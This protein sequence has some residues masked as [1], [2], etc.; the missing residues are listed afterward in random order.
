MF[1]GHM[2]G[3]SRKGEPGLGLSRSPA[4][5]HC[6]WNG[7][8]VFST[9]VHSRD[10]TRKVCFNPTHDDITNIEGLHFGQNK[11]V[12]D[13]IKG[14]GKVKVDNINCVTLVYHMRHRFLED[15][16]T[17]ETRPRK[18]RMAASRSFQRFC[19]L[20]I[21]GYNAPHVV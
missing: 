21:L 16:P 1:R 13:G 6:A 20:Y 4:E 19:I 8:R 9:D 18:E 11:S 2:G 3:R 10:P 14:L 5:H 7:P 12:G 15:H 17:G